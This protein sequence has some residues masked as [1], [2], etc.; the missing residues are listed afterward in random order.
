MSKEQPASEQYAI[1]EVAIYWRPG[2]TGHGQEVTIVGAPSWRHVRDRVT[3]VLVNRFVYPLAELSPDG[4]RWSVSP[5]RLRKKKPPRKDL[6]VVRW[7]QCP[8]Q[9]ESLNV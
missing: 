2:A 9:P 5:D 1:G 6:E 8:W 7:D 3:G 4:K